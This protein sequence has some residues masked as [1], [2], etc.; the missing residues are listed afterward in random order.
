[1]SASRLRP[2]SVRQTFAIAWRAS[3]SSQFDSCV[4]TTI[5]SSAKRTHRHGDLFARTSGLYE[6]PNVARGHGEIWLT[7]PDGT[8]FAAPELIV[9]HIDEHQYLPPNEFIEAVQS[10]VPTPGVT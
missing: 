8:N 10:G 1:M 3:A 2:E 6:A 9:H 7:A 5:A 4:G